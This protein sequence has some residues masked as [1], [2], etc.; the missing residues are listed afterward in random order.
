LAEKRNKLARIKEGS[1]GRPGNYDG[2]D[3]KS[4]QGKGSYAKLAKG[5]KTLPHV[6][7]Q[8]K[9]KIRKKEGGFSGRGGTEENI[10][11]GMG[12]RLNEE[13]EAR[14]FQGRTAQAAT[15]EESSSG[16]GGKRS[17]G[18]ENQ[19]LALL[20]IGPGGEEEAENFLQYV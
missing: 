11:K 15:E 10:Q 12:I 13:W 4:A 6:N 19:P 2:G 14:S 18:K 20:A 3:R 1:L 5:G 17:R 9:G 8:I 16:E 7:S